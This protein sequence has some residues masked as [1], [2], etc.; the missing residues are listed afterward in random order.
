MSAELSVGMII[1]SV[2]F[3]LKRF[4]FFISRVNKRS[5][6]LNVGFNSYSITA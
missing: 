6:L 2:L 5:C 4:R 3:S 1:V